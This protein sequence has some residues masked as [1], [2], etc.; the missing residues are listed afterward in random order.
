MPMRAVVLCAQV[1][2]SECL[3]ILIVFVSL[4]AQIAYKAHGASKRA[5]E[6][7]KTAAR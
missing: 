2:A 4:A 6:A 7:Q 1:N 5:A 3:G